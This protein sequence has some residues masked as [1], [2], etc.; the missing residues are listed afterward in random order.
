MKDAQRELGYRRIELRKES[1]KPK[2]IF[3]EPIRKNHEH[4]K[5]KHEHIV[6]TVVTNTDEARRPK[7]EISFTNKLG[8]TEEETKQ[9][10]QSALVADTTGSPTIYKPSLFKRNL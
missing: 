1:V 3:S 6:P 10:K 2:P 8:K 5:E 4:D 7:K 9:E